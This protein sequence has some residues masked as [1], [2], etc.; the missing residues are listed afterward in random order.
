MADVSGSLL[1]VDAPE[2]ALVADCSL[3]GEASLIDMLHLSLTQALE[4][5][6]RS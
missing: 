5:G 2:L 4:A 1:S 6:L 3:A